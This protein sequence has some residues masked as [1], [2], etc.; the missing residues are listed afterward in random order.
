MNPAKILAKN[1][2]DEMQIS[3]ENANILFK[4]TFG[5]STT[6]WPKTDSPEIHYPATFSWGEHSVSQAEL[7]LTREQEDYGFA[8]LEHC[9][10]YLCAIQIHTT[11]DSLRGDNK[12][13]EQ[14][15]EDSFQIARQ[16]RNAFAHDPFNP[17]WDIKPQFNNKKY[18]IP[19]IIFLDTT[20]LDGKAVNRR[21]Y[22]G[23][24]AI[25]RFIE[26]TQGVLDQS[27]KQQSGTGS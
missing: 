22:G 18:E 21:D 10:T 16:I 15:R 25:L 19:G 5:L 6:F 27:F 9:S 12:F 1:E 26:Y 14:E 23:P 3:L 17:R 2:Y 7:R 4:L 13:P 20:G 11:L 24:L 8:I